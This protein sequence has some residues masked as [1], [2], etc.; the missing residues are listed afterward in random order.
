[1]PRLILFE[2]KKMLSRRVALA[3][4][5]GVIVFLV[6]IMALNVTQNRTVSFAGEEFNGVEALAYNRSEDEKHAGVVTA[7]RAAED[8]AAYQEMVFSRIDRDTVGEM[9]GARSTPSSRKASRPR[10]SMTSTTSTGTG[11]CG[12]GGLRARSPRRRLPA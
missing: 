10:R 8:I 9:T 1:M 5:V 11:F 7:E 3:A 4:N 2:I 12:P 6:A